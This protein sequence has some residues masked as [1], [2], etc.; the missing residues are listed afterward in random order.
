MATPIQRPVEVFRMHPAALWLTVLVALLLQ[1]VLPLELPLARLF[2]FPLLATIYFAVI[3]RD[4]IV[5]IGLGTGVGLLQDA[6]S[7]GLIGVFGMA[8]GLVGYLAASASVRFELDDLFGRLALTAT[9]V[10]IHAVFLKLLQRALLET[11]PPWQALDLV[12]GSLVNIGLGL[13]LFQVLDR[14]RRPV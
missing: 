12:S 11:P 6:L 13:I 10:P 5:A 7:S 3:R 14:F 4:K 9:L 2:D 1:T 8:K